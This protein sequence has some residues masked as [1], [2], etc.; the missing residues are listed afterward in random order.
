MASMHVVIAGAGGPIAD[1][2]P[3]SMSRSTPSN[4]FDVAKLMRFWT[5]CARFVLLQAVP[6]LLLPSPPIW[7]FALT[8][9]ECAV[10]THFG[11]SIFEMLLV[12]RFGPASVAKLNRSIWVRSFH[13]MFEEGAQPTSTVTTSCPEAEDEA[14]TAP[15]TAQ[16]K[17]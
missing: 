1:Q 12:S 13:G 9:C 3:S 14:A 11:T 2:G 16:R 15:D 6:Q 10:A 5:N 17:R 8:P 4:P 7:I